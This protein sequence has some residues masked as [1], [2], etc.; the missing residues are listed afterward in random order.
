MLQAQEAGRDGQT[1]V[2]E[3]T[4]TPPAFSEAAET[5]AVHRV[6]DRTR[7]H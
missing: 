5:V 6:H 7:E 3:S 4:F 2:V 1:R